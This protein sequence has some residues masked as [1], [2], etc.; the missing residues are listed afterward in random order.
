MRIRTL[1][2]VL[3]LSVFT[4]LFV[5]A[6]NLTNLNIGLESKL[7]NEGF[8]EISGKEF[9]VEYE[10]GERVF[11]VEGDIYAVVSNKYYLMV[12]KVFD[13]Y[14]DAKEVVDLYKNAKP[15][16]IG[17]E[18][19]KVYIGEYSSDKEAREDFDLVYEINPDMDHEVLRNNYRRISIMSGDGEE[20]IIDS[21][22]DNLFFDS[23]YK[24]EFLEDKYRG[25]FGFVRK[26]DN[27]L[28]LINR[29]DIN[30]YLKSVVPSEMPALWE[31][32]ALKA[33]AVAAR[34]YTY[35]NMS[36]H[37]EEG[38]N[39]CDTVHCQVYKGVMTEHKN[40]SEAVMETE[41]DLLYYGDNLVET[42]FF[43]RSG[44]ATED[45]E[46]V[47][48]KEV[49]YLRSVEDE[50]EQDEIWLI[51]PDKEI[52]SIEIKDYYNSGSV[53]SIYINKKEYKKANGRYFLGLRSNK[54]RIKSFEGKV[55]ANILG[56]SN[57]NRP[58]EDINIFSND[59]KLKKVYILGVDENIKEIDYESGT[60]GLI[61]EGIGYGHGVGM[62]QMGA[63]EYAKRNYTYKQILSHYYTGSI[64]KGEAIDE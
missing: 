5:S 56:M 53:A 40:S 52:S 37:I 20:F 16:Y 38:Y 60:D 3:S 10:S 25:K 47:W 7:S 13:S 59:K 14:E 2:L 33:Q 62:S 23:N 41:G 21:R 55:Y 4:S 36:K 64:V 12:S 29:I 61:I 51:N 6:E 8:I 63:N 30:N 54:Y 11:K 18:E 39:L 48:S 58:Y 44:G 27:D 46:N 17:N 57:N 24:F 50:F 26:N 9:K 49:D 19:W 34:N 15:V 28:I 1:F 35:L 31:K 43:A 32:E 22:D 45:S 42:Y